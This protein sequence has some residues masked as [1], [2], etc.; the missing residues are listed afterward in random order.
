[1]TRGADAGA[2]PLLSPGRPYA[3]LQGSRHHSHTFPSRS[4]SPHSFGDFP[5]SSCVSLQLF[6]SYQAF[7]S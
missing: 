3:S 7:S 2:G 6:P 4:Y 5:F 1:M